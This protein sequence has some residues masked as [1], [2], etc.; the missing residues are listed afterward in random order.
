MAVGAITALKSIGAIT[1]PTP[2]EAYG[3]V[4]AITAPLAYYAYHKRHHGT[5]NKTL[6]THDVTS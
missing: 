6:S 3:I 5:C 2:T 1:A 4:G